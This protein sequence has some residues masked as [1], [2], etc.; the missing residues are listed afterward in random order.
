[1]VPGHCS[2][3]AVGT[4]QL[5]GAGSALTLAPLGSILMGFAAAGAVLCSP[6]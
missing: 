4:G 6:L 2:A 1:M 3:P 5:P